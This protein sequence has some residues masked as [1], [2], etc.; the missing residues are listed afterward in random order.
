[1][2]AAALAN[3]ANAWNTS[4]ARQLFPYHRATTAASLWGITMKHRSHLLQSENYRARA[5]LSERCAAS[6]HDKSVKL[7]WQ[8]LAIEWHLLAARTANPQPVYIEAA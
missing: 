7:Q 5:L 6:T 1:L 3:G 2:H 8:E 4:V